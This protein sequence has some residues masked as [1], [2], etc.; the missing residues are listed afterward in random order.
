[1]KHH[2]WRAI[3]LLAFLLLGGIARADQ[4]TYVYTDPQG[5]PL[6][7]ADE[8]GN[9]TKTFDYTPYGMLA[10]GEQ[11]NGPGYTGH[12]NDPETNLLYMQARYYDAA[13]GQFL[14]VDPM[15]PKP[16]QPFGFNR[17]AYANNNPI[18]NTDPD[19]RCPVCVAIPVFI[20][21]MAH[22]DYAN[23]PGPNDRPVSLSTVDHLSAVTEALPP[24]RAA[25]FIRMGVKAEKAGQ[26]VAETSK[27]ARR[28]AMRD[29]RYTY[30]PAARLTV[31]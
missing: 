13:T 2:V 12:V 1:M 21:L 7:E 3:W 6:A 14:S 8:H 4:D 20:G 23:A 24:G 15:G 22:S 28:E 16:G 18:V 25:S 31:S 29:G 11:P 9:I 27:A 30:E 5:T 26:K 19:G 10:A 17:Y